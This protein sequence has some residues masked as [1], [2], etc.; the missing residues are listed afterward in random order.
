MRVTVVGAGVIGLTTALT[1]EERGHDVRIVAAASALESVSGIAGAVWFPYRAGPPAKVA[2]WAA[3]TRS[4]LEGLA[5]ERDAGIDVL[6]AYEITADRGLAPPVPWWAAGID[7]ARAPAPVHGAPLA[8]RFRAPR[9]T[10]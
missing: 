8:W 1:L 5:V 2:R 10:A 3:R 4:W 9:A 6:T 7:V